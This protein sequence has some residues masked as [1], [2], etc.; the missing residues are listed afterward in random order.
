MEWIPTK[1]NETKR[2]MIPL[3]LPIVAFLLSAVGAKSH[4]INGHSV[5]TGEAWQQCTLSNDSPLADELRIRA[6]WWLHVPKNGRDFARTLLAAAGLPSA[7]GGSRREEEL[8]AK[9]PWFRGHAG[10]PVRDGGWHKCLPIPLNKSLLLLG[11]APP[12]TPLSAVSL[13][14]AL[15]TCRSAVGF[16]REPGQRLLS[17]YFHS[18][19]LTFF[20]PAAREAH[21]RAAAAGFGLG[22]RLEAMLNAS[23]GCI[24][25]EEAAASAD[26]ARLIS[27]S[28]TSFH[29]LK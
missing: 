9:G 18:R 6:L 15:P 19:E 17:S 26:D 5:V 3:L 4:N 24:F 2:D 28:G 13:A 23:A 10:F 20:D 11:G 22:R 21:R 12:T 29:P 7:A 14:A 25:G 8:Y 1:R 16:F 27:A